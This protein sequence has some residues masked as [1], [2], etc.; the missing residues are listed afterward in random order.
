[1]KIIKTGLK[2]QQ[3]LT[4]MDVIYRTG[5]FGVATNIFIPFSESGV[6]PFKLLYL[7]CGPGES[8]CADIHY[9]VQS[10][11]EHHCYHSHAVPFHQEGW[12]KNISN[13][14]NLPEGWKT[15]RSM[16][17]WK[18]FG[19]WTRDISPALF[20]LPGRTFEFEWGRQ[21]EKLKRQRLRRTLPMNWRLPVS[22]IQGYLE[23]I[24]S[25]KDMPEQTKQDFLERYY[26]K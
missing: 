7:W 2:L 11:G 6:T 1:M 21:S 9:V 5:N 4:G 25:N 13:L 12:E 17:W 16:N 8:L 3:A 14:Q 19:R 18:V 10:G 24:K 26:A 23:T 15:N 22:S 20:G